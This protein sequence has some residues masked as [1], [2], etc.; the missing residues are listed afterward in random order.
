MP[1]VLRQFL[2]AKN[3][4]LL[5]SSLLE[6]TLFLHFIDALSAQSLFLNLQE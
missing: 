2:N 4:P 1:I 3:P 5:T 6:G